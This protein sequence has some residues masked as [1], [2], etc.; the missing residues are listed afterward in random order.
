MDCM[1][2]HMQICQCALFMSGSTLM[3][4]TLVATHVDNRETF[5][6][7]AHKERFLHAAE[8][9]QVIDTRK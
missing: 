6:S 5:R 1:C 4:M 8:I 2:V 9:L 3:H 7:C